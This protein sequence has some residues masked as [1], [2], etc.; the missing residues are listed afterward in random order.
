MVIAAYCGLPDRLISTFSF[1]NLTVPRLPMEPVLR[2]FDDT[3]EKEGTPRTIISRTRDLH[4]LQR[5]A[6]HQGSIRCSYQGHDIKAP[7]NTESH[8]SV[9]NVSAIFHLYQ[10]RF[11]DSPSHLAHT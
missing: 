10:Q 7:P 1:V 11:S 3:K 8:C 4:V 5:I 2:A 9:P 6:R